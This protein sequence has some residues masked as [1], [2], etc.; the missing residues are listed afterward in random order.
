MQEDNPSKDN[1]WFYIC[2]AIPLASVV[3]SMIIVFNAVNTTDSLVVGNYYKEGMAIN[4]RTEK[5]DRAR[6]LG[7]EVN[8]SLEGNQ[9]KI[10][11][12]V[13]EKSS[14]QNAI[15][16]FRHPTL[17][18]KDFSVAFKRDKGNYAV[19]LP[20]TIEGK[21]YVTVHDEEH[22]WEMAETWQI[23]AVSQIEMR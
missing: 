1:L 2:L 17:K 22:T 5:L 23:N 15:V 20:E 21:W 6:H 10:A 4:E 16:E 18:A 12:N 13:F 7:L 14:A 8:L 3:S 9:L 11:Q 19:T